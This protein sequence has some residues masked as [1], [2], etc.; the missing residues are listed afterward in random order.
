VIFKVEASPLLFSINLSQALGYKKIQAMYVAV[1]ST[2]PFSKMQK[3]IGLRICRR[4]VAVR[5]KHHGAI[6]GYGGIP[7]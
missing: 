6:T 3:G 1:N 5:L 7:G 4:K 2:E